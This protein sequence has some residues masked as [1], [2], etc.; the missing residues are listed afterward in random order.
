RAIAETV[1]EEGRAA[2]RAEYEPPAA[3]KMSPAR[4][5]ALEGAFAPHMRREVEMLASAVTGDDLLKAVLSSI[6]IKVSKRGGEPGRALARG[7]AARLL[8]HRAEELAAGL[9]ALWRKAPPRTR[10]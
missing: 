4:Q 2:R 7:M 1:I 8:V 9:D 5:K 6:A 10:A 3:P